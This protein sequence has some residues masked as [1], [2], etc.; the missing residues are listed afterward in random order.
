A[1][2]LALVVGGGFDP[3]V[4]RSDHADARA[5]LGLGGQH[6]QAGEGDQVYA[7]VHRLYRVGHRQGGYVQRFRQQARGRQG[8]NAYRVQ[9]DVQTVFGVDTFVVGDVDGDVVADGR[10]AQLHFL[11]GGRGDGGNAR[12]GEA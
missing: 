7:A 10:H 4:R 8:G 6:T 9:C 5:A 11:L 3:G 2:R 12:T 1:D